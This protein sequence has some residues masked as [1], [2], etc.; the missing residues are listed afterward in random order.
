LSGKSTLVGRPRFAAGYV[1]RKL[2][3]FV[4]NPRGPH[5]E[6][7]RHHHQVTG[8]EPTIQPVGIAEAAGKDSKRFTNAIQDQRQALLVPGL[9]ALQKLGD[10][11]IEDR[12]LDGARAPSSL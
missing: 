2:R 11:E 1:G 12:G 9:V 3:E 5:S 6:Q 7:H 4:Q 10:L 8:A